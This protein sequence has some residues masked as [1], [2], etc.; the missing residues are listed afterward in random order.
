M[1][2][3]FAGVHTEVFFLLFQVPAHILCLNV[4]S[5][6]NKGRCISE[7]EKIVT[8]TPKSSIL[9]KLSYSL[10][11]LTIPTRLLDSSGLSADLF[12]FIVRIF[13]K[14]GNFNHI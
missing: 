7:I 13:N 12:I 4:A 6:W 10:S 9:V 11:Y 2:Y 1:Q 14:F 8:V 5:G 3:P